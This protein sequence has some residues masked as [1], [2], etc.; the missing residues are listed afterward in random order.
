MRFPTYL[1]SKYFG[2]KP[3][4]I[5]LGDNAEEPMLNLILG[6]E[7]LANIALV[8]DF[9]QQTIIDRISNVTKQYEAFKNTIFLYQ[10]TREE[11]MFP[12]PNLEYIS[13]C[14]ATKQTVNILDA[15]HKK[16]DLPEIQNDICIHLDC[17]QQVKLLILVQKN[18]E[19]CDSTLGDLKTDP[20]KFHL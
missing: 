3:S 13:T 5:E 17:L 4:I 19:L 2:I 18:K 11:L 6:V 20:G 16:V 8:L 1:N 10:I 15:K 9:G 14:E 12:R 7:S